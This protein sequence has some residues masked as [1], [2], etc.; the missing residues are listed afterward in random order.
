MTFHPWEVG[1]ILRE[2]VA[3][4]YNVPAGAIGKEVKFHLSTP[5]DGVHLSGVEVDIATEGGA[6]PIRPKEDVPR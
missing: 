3:R 2:F 4:E 1:E 5:K 6:R